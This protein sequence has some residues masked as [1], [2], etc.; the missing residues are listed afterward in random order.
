V[1]RCIECG[2]VKRRQW[3]SDCSW[4]NVVASGQS[5]KACGM[6]TPGKR[7]LLRSPRHKYHSL[8]RPSDTCRTRSCA[9]DQ[10]RVQ[11]VPKWKE[12]RHLRPQPN[13]ASSVCSGEEGSAKLEGLLA[14]P[15]HPHSHF[16]VAWTWHN[17]YGLCLPLCCWFQPR[18][19]PRT[20]SQGPFLKPETSHTAVQQEKHQCPLEAAQFL[21]F[22][23]KEISRRLKKGTKWH[24]KID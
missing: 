24:K 23:C 22:I 3:A 11:R 18:S 13:G 2:C 17:V 1:C 8:G 21:L 12:S 10:V 9:L 16:K 6:A 7:G 19:R 14:C 20:R 15:G 5:C 4:G